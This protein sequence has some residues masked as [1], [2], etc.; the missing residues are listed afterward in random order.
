[1]ADLLIAVKL[2]SGKKLSADNRKVLGTLLKN[3]FPE[4]PDIEPW[5]EASANVIARDR[6]ASKTKLVRK[7]MVEIRAE[8]PDSL[9]LTVKPRAK[10]AYV[11][12]F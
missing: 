9:K 8:G 1:M 12:I 5:L 10:V 7:I 6:T 11:E 2:D 4:W 3:I